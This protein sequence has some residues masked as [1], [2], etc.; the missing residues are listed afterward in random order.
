VTGDS[1]AFNNWGPD[2]PNNDFGDNPNEDRMVYD[3]QDN[4]KGKEWNDIPD[5]YPTRGFVVEFP[6]PPDCFST[7]AAVTSWGRLKVMYR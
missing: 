4:A 2:E 3:H 7:P 1:V 6:A 5:S